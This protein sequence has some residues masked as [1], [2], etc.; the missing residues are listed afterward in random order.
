M[1]TTENPQLAHI[2][3]RLVESFD[4]LWDNFVDPTDAFCD[5][6]GLRWTQVGATGA[7]GATGILPVSAPFSD[8]SQLVQIRNQC[9]LLAMQ[10]EFAINGHEKRVT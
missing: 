7:A 1:S 5:H 2:E 4:R 6:D 9:R 8:E 3:R 10:N